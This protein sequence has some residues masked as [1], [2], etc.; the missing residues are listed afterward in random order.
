MYAVAKSMVVPLDRGGDLAVHSHETMLDAKRE[1]KAAKE[2]TS[3][4]TQDLL[5]KCGGDA[6]SSQGSSSLEGITDDQPERPASENSHDVDEAWNVHAYH[7]RSPPG[8]ST[9]SDL[10][11]DSDD[12]LEVASLDDVAILPLDLG[13]DSAVGDS[14][15]CS[16]PTARFE[17]LQRDPPAESANNYAAR[18]TNDDDVAADLLVEPRIDEEDDDDDDDDGTAPIHALELAEPPPRPLNDDDD[19]IE[20]DG[21]DVAY[22]IVREDLEKEEPPAVVS[23]EDNSFEEPPPAELANRVTEEGTAVDDDQ[24]Q[25]LVDQLQEE[26]GASSEQCERAPS[27]DQCER[28]PSSEQCERASSEQDSASASASSGGALVNDDEYEEDLG[29]LGEERP[30]QVG[31]EPN[32]ELMITPADGDVDDGLPRVDAASSSSVL[33]ASSTTTTGFLTTFDDDMSVSTLSAPSERA[34]RNS[35]GRRRR[36]SGSDSLS[37]YLNA[38]HQP[39]NELLQHPLFKR[40]PPAGESADD[41]SSKDEGLV[42]PR[43]SAA[44][45]AALS[46][47]RSLR[48]SSRQSS[49]SDVVADYDDSDD[50]AVPQSSRGKPPRRGPPPEVTR[51]SPVVDVMAEVTRTAEAHQVVD[52]IDDDS[53]DD[54]SVDPQN[55]YGCF[56]L[57]TAAT[58]ATKTRK[59]TVSVKRISETLSDDGTLDD[60]LL[61]AIP[62]TKL[63]NHP[64]GTAGTDD[65]VDASYVDSITRSLFGW[66]S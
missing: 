44:T 38:Q 18:T 3:Q 57:P 23:D 21:H 56:A 1:A 48:T 26:P 52:V 2:A 13:G 64:A 60:D 10:D 33:V 42:D 24:D 6:A 46:E 34:F 45:T 17:P 19:V 9:Y 5:D 58:T 36:S 22:P 8:S 61:P 59:T 31:S 11:D 27:S 25:P 12:D 30:S 15:V 50:D 28:A 43:F 20:E 4:A 51:A 37:Q 29:M 40:P 7:L 32:D 14:T 53:G 65:D 66:V 63:Q 47:R 55:A 16:S 54:Y 41:D 39:T 49:K 35:L 62:V